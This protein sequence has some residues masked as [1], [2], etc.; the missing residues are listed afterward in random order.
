VRADHL[1]LEALEEQLSAAARAER[2]VGLIPDRRLAPARGIRGPELVERR[3]AGTG[4][5]ED[6]TESMS[7]EIAV[8]LSSNSHLDL[9]T[10]TNPKNGA[11]AFLVPIPASSRS[12]SVN[13]GR[14]PAARSLR[15]ADRGPYP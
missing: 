12:R 8:K 11:R 1:V 13:W 7:A 2:L 15:L 10:G 9:L 14:D 6:L 3:A 5:Y 4:G